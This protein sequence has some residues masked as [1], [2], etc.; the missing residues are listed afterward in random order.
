[1]G[2]SRSSTAVTYGL[3]LH[4]ADEPP[5]VA[6]KKRMVAME[7]ERHIMGAD[8]TQEHYEQSYLATNQEFEDVRIRVE[9]RWGPSNAHLEPLVKG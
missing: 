9:Y 1:M 5:R 2:G 6:E 3:V 4:A 7:N 8:V